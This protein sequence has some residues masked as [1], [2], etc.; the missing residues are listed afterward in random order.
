M[1]SF[2]NKHHYQL[3]IIQSIALYIATGHTQ[4]TNTQNLLDKTRVVLTDI[5]L[6]LH[7]TQLKQLNQ[8]Q[9]HPFYLLNVHSD[10]L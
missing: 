7:A 3:Q 6:K 10:L 4:D 5:H 1:K 8:T 9:T 2:H